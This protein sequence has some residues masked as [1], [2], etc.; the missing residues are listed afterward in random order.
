M[1]NYSVLG[2]LLRVT[3]KIVWR[4]PPRFVS[5]VFLASDIVCFM[6]QGAAAS[7]LVSFDIDAVHLGQ[8]I[9]YF[10][11]SLQMVF[12]TVFLAIA[13]RAS[14]LPEL[15]PASSLL[16]R[17]HTVWIVLWGTM[18]LLYGEAQSTLTQSVTRRPSLPSTYAARNA[19]RVAEFN[20]LDK[21]GAYASSNEWMFYVFD[22]VTIIACC[23][24]FSVWHYGILL[25]NERVVIRDI[26]VSKASIAGGSNAS[27]D[28]SATVVTMA[29]LEGPSQGVSG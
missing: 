2:V 13:L 23:V 17:V 20:G 18:A 26:Q 15:H 1:V 5:R 8:N 3:G 6:I 4:L 12:F 7:Q 22:G 29:K 25:G 14:R 19:Y 28:Q 10:G 16:P 27:I 24:A 9:M 21:R 11:L